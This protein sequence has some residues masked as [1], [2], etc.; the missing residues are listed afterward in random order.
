MCSAPFSAK[1][2]GREA[3]ELGRSA[4]PPCPRL[5]AWARGSR[6]EPAVK[7][8]RPRAGEPPT[9]R[10][11]TWQEE[12]RTVRPGPGVRRACSYRAGAPAATPLGPG[13][14]V[15]P[16]RP[17]VIGAD[18]ARP[19]PV[20]APSVQA[21]GRAGAAEQTSA[22]AS[23]PT[24]SIDP[25]GSRSAEDQ[26]PL[27]AGPRRAAAT[28]LRLGPRARSPLR[29]GPRAR[30]PRPMTAPGGARGPRAPARP[31]SRGAEP[32]RWRAGQ[33]LP[34]RGTRA[35]E[36]PRDPRAGSASPGPAPTAASRPRELTSR[37]VTLRWLNSVTAEALE[38]R[39]STCCVARRAHL[40][41]PNPTPTPAWSAQ[42]ALRPRQLP[43][44]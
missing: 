36:S 40:R 15:E 44:R 12:P 18:E 3:N 25:L 39:S 16:P 27:Q 4:D 42:A 24:S 34:L 31:R 35:A 23:R 17:R 5:R 9:Q 28:R 13:P 26:A 11:M 32:V 43:R 38:H 2:R 6:R 29:L 37:A 19:Q 21:R 8:A 22:Q 33:T 7:A 20:G 1:E 30:S 41:A 10:K 14:R